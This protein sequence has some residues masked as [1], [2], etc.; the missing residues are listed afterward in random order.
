M[1]RLHIETSGS[2]PAI[3]FTHGL[4]DSASTWDE[5][6]AHLSRR[7]S[8]LRWD[9]LGHGRSE[10]PEESEAYSR[11]VAYA[12]LQNM[13]ARTQADVV[14]AGHSFGGY[15][16]MCRAIRKP[17]GVRGLVLIA[18]GPGFRDPEARERWN[19]TIR[20]AGERLGISTAATELAVQP[21]TLVMSSLDAITMPVLL[22]A[23]AK[24]KGFQGAMTY[25][26][27]RLPVATALSVPD[28]GHHVHRTHPK[29]VN[30]A[31]DAFV[32][33]LP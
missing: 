12:D 7:F 28:A 4:G 15:L 19:R 11:E 10:K 23:G 33:S 1:S 13:L 22:I 6:A 25:L 14:L 2:G 21:D 5:Q 26:A 27:R 17:A 29:V 8:V 30:P 20:G 9:L 32:D 24:D 31:I 16:S 18:T 3:V